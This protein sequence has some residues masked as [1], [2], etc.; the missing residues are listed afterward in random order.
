MKLLNLDPRLPDSVLSVQVVGRD[1]SVIH[2]QLSMP[3]DMFEAF[4]SVLDSLSS[5]FSFLQIK[6]KHYEVQSRVFSPAEIQCRQDH[7]KSYS[8]FILK[9]FDK[10]IR[11]GVS[12]KESIKQIL[13]LTKTK[14][15]NCSHDVI[16]QILRKNGRLKGHNTL[17][18]PP[19]P[20]HLDHQPPRGA[21]D[22]GEALVFGL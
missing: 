16:R 12:P 7:F 9:N 13:V 15:G 3:I 4:K 19:A 22:P 10:L 1:E 8:G 2:V 18:Y 11:S 17:I 14:F 20:L 5:M 6:A 21:G